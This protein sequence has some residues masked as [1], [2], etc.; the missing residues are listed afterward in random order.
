MAIIWHLMTRASSVRFAIGSHPPILA[1]IRAIIFIHC[2]AGNC[3]TPKRETYYTMILSSTI[4][5]TSD[6]TLPVFEKETKIGL[7]ALNE[8]LV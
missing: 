7:Q 5:I 2:T 1:S 8:S 6:V 4:T 3:T